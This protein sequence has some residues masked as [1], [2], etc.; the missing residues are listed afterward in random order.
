MCLRTESKLHVFKLYFMLHLWYP[1]TPP[2]Y[3]FQ[4]L[5]KWT[6]YNRLVL[7]SACRS[8]LSL[9]FVPLYCYTD[10]CNGALMSL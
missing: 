1:P 5:W 7:H 4:P 2:I 9:V 10:G 8:L 6:N 3:N